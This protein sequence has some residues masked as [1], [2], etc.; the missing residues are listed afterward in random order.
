M[1]LSALCSTSPSLDGALL[2]ARRAT[3]LYNSP[4]SSSPFPYRTYPSPLVSL[5]L[6]LLSILT[7]RR[8][9]WNRAVGNELS[10]TSEGDSRERG[11][12]GANV[13]T[14]KACYRL[15]SPTWYCCSSGY[16]AARTS[17][18]SALCILRERERERERRRTLAVPPAECLAAQTLAPTR[19]NANTMPKPPATLAVAATPSSLTSE[20]RRLCA[21]GLSS[22]RVFGTAGS[23]RGRTSR[24]R[25]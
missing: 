6:S 21:G 11:R 3:S 10:A 5:S 25:R 9:I 23:G 17:G 12:V 19:Q 20:L 16:S 7:P 2:P 13:V 24:S 14:G 1:S 18:S 4:L 15:R 22:A 8:D